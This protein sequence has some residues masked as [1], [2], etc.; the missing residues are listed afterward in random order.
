MSE[1]VFPTFLRLH[2]R[3]V[4]LVGGGTVARAKLEALLPDDLQRWTD[5]ARDLRQRWRAER[6]P[7]EQRRP[8]LLEALNRIYD[9]SSRSSTPHP[10]PPHVGG[11]DLS[12]LMGRK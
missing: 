5:V 6:V 9:H 3:K 2:R 12:P 8:L 1:A 7:I 10:I 11:G 4:V